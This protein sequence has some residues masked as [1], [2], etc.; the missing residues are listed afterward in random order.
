MSWT[1][2]GVRRRQPDHG[3]HR[4]AVHRRD[5]ADAGRRSARDRDERDRDRADE[6]HGVHVPRARRSTPSATSTAVRG[7][8]PRST[9]QATIFDFAHA[10]GRSTRRT[11]TR[12]SSASS[13]APTHN[14]SIT[15][16]RFYKSAANTRH[17][18]RH[19]V[20]ARRARG[21][22][23]ATFTGESASGWQTV[24]FASPVGDHRRHDLRR[25]LLRARR[26]LLGHRRRLDRRR[27]TTGRCTRWRTR[28]SANGVYAY[29]ATSTFPTSTLQRGELLGRRAVRRAHARP[30]RRRRRPP[31]RAR[32]RRPCRGR[33]PPAAAP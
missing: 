31:R 21:W 11:T 27:S 19:A 7:V 17:A 22:R 3:L 15:G 23:Q 28:R 10:D 16:I 2:P 25:V 8:A 33:R 12:S 5:R 18:R 29:G 9:P 13:S 20:D 30:G 1:P 26:P 32:R 24:T 14:G 6:R 4:H